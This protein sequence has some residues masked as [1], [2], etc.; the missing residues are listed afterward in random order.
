MI[1]NVEN[2]QKYVKYSYITKFMFYGCF[3]KISMAKDFIGILDRHTSQDLLFRRFKK[4]QKK[5]DPFERKFT[6]PK[7]CK[8][9]AMS[10]H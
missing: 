3:K 4:K 10:L 7:L 1:N 5:T 6:D 2:K 9:K 8:Y